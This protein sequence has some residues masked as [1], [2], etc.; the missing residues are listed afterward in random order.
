MMI[1]K[2]NAEL[3]EKYGK[4]RV[5]PILDLVNRIPEGTYSRII[6]IGC[7]S[8]MSTLPLKQRFEKAE[9]WGVDYSKEML[10]KAMQV[11]QKIR[12]EQRD[13]SKPLTDLGHFDLVFSNAFLQWLQNQ[14][15]F[16]AY[17][18]KLLNEKGIFAL[19]VPNYDNMP[20]KK[21]VDQVIMPFGERF[22]EVEKIICHNKSLP[23]YYDILCRYFSEVTIWQTN[24]AHVMQQYEDIVKFVSATGIRP[25]LQVLNEEEQK[26]FENRLIKEL[27]KVYPVQ[28]NGK[29]LFT[30]ERIEFVA[31]K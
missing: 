15:A 13:C 12:W 1:M 4:E 29:I 14:E 2:W 9:I 8:G 25:Y 19:Q 7:G 24:Y 23:E 21:C 26:R 11:S 22:E 16:I 10:E 17:V 5:Q 6:D 28:A 30:F 27:K 18:A 3:Y 20:I 31:K